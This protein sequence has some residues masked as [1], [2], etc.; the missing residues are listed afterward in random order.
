MSVQVCRT[1]SR[2]MVMTAVCSV[3][4]PST[5]LG[6]SDNDPPAPMRFDAHIEGYP[7][8]GLEAAEDC[9]LFN[10]TLPMGSH[11]V[12]SAC[13]WPRYGAQYQCAGSPNGPCG[14]SDSDRWNDGW[15]WL[16]CVQHMGTLG[17]F[18]LN[19]DLNVGI[20]PAGLP[21]LSYSVA[22]GTSP[23]VPPS[24][25][26]DGGQVRWP[27]Q[28]VGETVDAVTGTPLIQETDLALPFG[29]A[30]F[31]HTRT[32]GQYHE[33]RHEMLSTGDE[34]LASV[35]RNAV[36]GGEFWESTGNGWTMTTSPVLLIDVQYQ[37][38][39][40]EP[41][42][43]RRCV[44][45]PD[46]HHAISFIQDTTSD[47]G[48]YV[49]ASHFGAQLS[50]NGTWV[51]DSSNPSG[52]Y[53][54]IRPTVYR[55][56]L[57]DGAV[58]YTIKPRYEDVFPGFIPTQE[59]RD[60][61]MYSDH[62]TPDQLG[63]C[64]NSLPY[65]GLAE[66]IDDRYGNCIDLEYCEFRARNY[67][68]PDEDPNPDC[69]ECTV[70]YNE[71][72]QVARVRLLSGVE[73]DATSDWMN[74]GEWQADPDHPDAHPFDWSGSPEPG[75]VEWTLLYTYRSFWT[76]YAYEN[77]DDP[78]L[79]FPHA[80]ARENAIH[81]IHAYEGER[82]AGLD[83]TCRTIHFEEFFNPSSA[84]N[85][86]SG[87][88][89]YKSHDPNLADLDP[90]D[91]LEL[92][93]F[94]SEDPYGDDWAYAVHYMYAEP[95][96]RDR[97][98]STV[99]SEDDDWYEAAYAYSCGNARGAARLLK[100]TVTQRLHE[101]DGSS[102]EDESTYRLYRYDAAGPSGAA[103]D[104]VG[105]VH[106]RHQTTTLQH[107]YDHAAIMQM[108]SELNDESPQHEWT[109]NDLITG[110]GP[111]GTLLDERLTE[112]GEDGDEIPEW[113]TRASRSLWEWDGPLVPSNYARDN[114][115]TG[116]WV[117]FQASQF[118]QVLAGADFAA[119]PNTKSMFLVPGVAMHAERGI[120]GA[121]RYFRTYRFYVSEQDYHS[122]ANAFV[123]YNDGLVPLR[124]V[125]HDPHRMPAYDQN[126]TWSSA[127]PVELRELGELAWVTVIDEYETLFEAAILDGWSTA[128]LPRTRRAVYQNAAGFVL[129]DRTW[130]FTDDGVLVSTDGYTETY[131]YDEH[132]RMTHIYSTGWN[133]LGNPVDILDGSFGSSQDDPRL[134]SGLVTRFEYWPAEERDGNAG[135]KGPLDIPME[136]R[137][138]GVQCGSGED[139]I[140]YYSEVTER[141][142]DGSSNEIIRFD[143][144]T[145]LHRFDTPTET[146]EDPFTSTPSTTEISY[147]FVKD[148]DDD[149]DEEPAQDWVITERT[150]LGPPVA[151][152]NSTDLYRARES[153]YYDA[154]DDE[155][156]GKRRGRLRWKAYGM[157]PLAGTSLASR[158]FDYYH[159]D[160]DGRVT[161]LVVDAA[162]GVS[163]EDLVDY[164][165][166]YDTQQLSQEEV[167]AYPDPSGRDDPDY[168]N[169]SPAH[170]ITKT[171]F[172]DRGPL[173]IEQP[174]GTQTHMSYRRFRSGVM[175]TRVARGFTS[176]VGDPIGGGKPRGPGTITRTGAESAVQHVTWDAWIS[177]DRLYNHGFSVIA[178]TEAETDTSGRPTAATQSD[179]RGNERR[180]EAQLDR[181]GM[182]TRRIEP[183]G[184]ITRTA[185]D[186]RG[187]PERVF[188][189]TEDGDAFW[190]NGQ[191]GG[192]EN[193]VLTDHFTY[194]HGETDAGLQI[195]SR[196]FR[197]RPAKSQYQAHNP[198]D[199]T[200]D[201]DGEGWLQQSLYDWR[202]RPVWQ[203]TYA[204]GDGQA[205]GDP[206]R[207]TI[208]LYD[209]L[210][211]VRFVASYGETAPTPDEQGGNAMVFNGIEYD[212]KLSMPSAEDILKTLPHTLTETVYNAAGQVER[213]IEYDT[214]DDTALT[215][216]ATSTYYDR[217]NKETFKTQPST[218][219]TIT[220]NDAEGR[221]LRRLTVLDPFTSSP[222]QIARTEYEYDDQGR[223]I[224]T[225]SFE[226]THHDAAAELTIDS[227]GNAVA[228]WQWSWYD[229]NGRLKATASLGTGNATSD[230]FVNSTP[231]TRTPD[232]PSLAS[233]GTVDR[234]GVPNY[235]ILT[236]YRYDAAG[237]QSAVATQ[238]TAGASPT[239]RVDRSYYDGMGNLRYSK[240]NAHGP[241][242]LRRTAY[243]YDPTT[244][245]LTHIAAVL[246]GHVALEYTGPTDSNAGAETDSSIYIEPDW[247]ADDGTLQVTMLEYQAEVYAGDG[248][249]P[250]QH[251]GWVSAVYLPDEATGQ[252]SSTPSLTF[253]YYPDGLVRSR[254][255][256]LGRLFTHTYDQFG[257]RTLTTID[258]N[259][260][261][262][263]PYEAYRPLDLAD[264][265]EYEY[266]DRDRLVR[267]TAVRDDNG[268]DV[269]IADNTYAYDNLGNLVAE[270]QSHGDAANPDPR[271]GDPQE[272]VGYLWDYA[273]H[274]VGNYLRLAA[275]AYP[276]RIQTGVSRSLQFS[277]G[278]ATDPAS[279]ALSRI[280]AIDD[281]TADLRAQFD[282]AGAGRRTGVH[283]QRDVSSNPATVWQH[284]FTDPNT[285]VGYPGLDRFG[286]PTDLRYVDSVG[287]DIH[288]YR[289]AYNAAGDRLAAEVEQAGHSNTRSW[290][291]GYDELSR[292]T[293]AERGTLLPDLSGL[294]HTAPTRAERTS[295]GL[296]TLGNWTE[297]AGYNNLFTGRVQELYDTS[298][299]DYTLF[300]EEHAHTTDQ[301]NRLR[302]IEVTEGNTPVVIETNA[303]D[304]AGNLIADADY[305]Y[306]Y[307][308][309]NRL[310]S[311]HSRGTLMFHA[312]GNIAG[313]TPGSWQMHMAYDAIGRLVRIQKPWGPAG[314]DHRDTL[315][316][317]DGV[318]RIV[319][320]FKDPV[321][322]PAVPIGSAQGSGYV[323]YTDREYVWGPD[324]IDECLW[325]ITRPGDVLHVLHD[326]S[327]DVVAL[328]DATGAVARQYTF[329]PYGQVIADE[330]FNSPAH[331]RLGH[332]GLFFDRLNTNPPVLELTAN[333]RGLYHNRNRTYD[334]RSG[335]FTS[336]DPNGTGAN[337]LRSVQRGRAVHPMS[338][339]SDNIELY[340]DGLSTYAYLGAAP[341]LQVD[342]FGLSWMDGASPL[343]MAL[344]PKMIGILKSV[345]AQIG[346][347]MVQHYARMVVAAEVAYGVTNPVPGASL[348]FP[349]AA[350]AAG[351]FGESILESLGGKTQVYF[352]TSLGR[353]FIDRLVGGIAYE[354]KTGFAD[355]TPAIRRQAEK[356][357]EL[358]RLGG[359]LA[360]RIE[361]IVWVFFTNPATGRQG[362]SSKLRAFLERQGIKVIEIVQ[363]VD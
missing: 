181:F 53:W 255:D 61:G 260:P 225:A 302:E 361:G 56:W 45:M 332:H 157:E 210:D 70:N 310:A 64:Y 176:P 100:T 328:L 111:D 116:D 142:R 170:R 237:R 192:D 290:L 4:V 334:P 96:R 249:P 182:M 326:A 201:F 29:S 321:V 151:L 40:G 119:L 257:R 1:F 330:S 195:T 89:W 206:L 47:S 180:V 84:G 283:A 43:A 28:L 109:V 20:G 245:Q 241:G 349:M 353:R 265:L 75:I 154:E 41:G 247:D 6:Q 145:A 68:H 39:A 171:L 102:W 348:G 352:R 32:F 226:R 325:Q 273:S 8:L 159:Y 117:A 150:T 331:N 301:R 251:N 87:A 243:K 196:S 350:Q 183:E 130:E 167:P 305:W 147:E 67:V 189:G 83:P 177:G 103:G 143:L 2:A 269:I 25:T 48:V 123:E 26:S 271:L 114:D 304:A 126:G 158:Y 175:E 22:E 216:H 313:G 186:P 244:G 323:T 148:V 335:R 121:E 184:T 312:D 230:Q 97:D 136:V 289:Y 11:W 316:Y 329:D 112:F 188:M 303:H 215:Y 5:A 358:L 309:F 187:R 168:I 345:E 101:P 286:R 311:V 197:A 55:V 207:H 259:W 113:D 356:D 54:S 288:R 205:D 235:A 165:G 179:W 73:F 9:E 132:G 44:F 232:S 262:N 233:D 88:G 317:Y 300:A 293:S 10:T 193:M 166:R 202:M 291:Y 94:A 62:D 95:L 110:I 275:M 92:E 212:S 224:S 363:E 141:L 79:S 314:S 278:D 23:L 344:A 134:T 307:D 46:A 129:M 125:L 267:A 342:P 219:A 99:E 63:A 12:P 295:W 127:T 74:G 351:R 18:P 66:R 58:C 120:G 93:V 76:G 59:D 78:E 152:D 277:Y 72:G 306:Q 35:A 133:S 217:R 198:Q 24:A 15:D 13:W 34:G 204:A 7:T 3:A 282:Y 347:V 163:L 21:P 82:E 236:C 252:P 85:G 139:A 60:D 160:E 185:T 231:P 270:Q 138:K 200:L 258:Y 229:Y 49:A 246:P 287:A 338:P 42:G 234:A 52:G 51:P 214:A 30:T 299:N 318:R 341:G 203:R 297:P 346:A 354:V 161:R 266:D 296:D 27:R 223:Q 268:N 228:T 71:K 222:Y 362:C 98:E 281:L 319:E 284:T 285:P 14:G 50:H 172:S 194:G 190:N 16:A 308:A 36:P 238:R 355:L 292:L 227:D 298:S 118:A 343:D 149:P 174:D 315:L 86:G 272:V 31:R 169:E 263:D 128:E 137:A 108:L 359:S 339:G 156:N 336:S 106:G 254:T 122:T 153:L 261:S 162:A 242:P 140:A 294:D 146:F 320:V 19:V 191:T 33:L 57:Y 105:Y 324:Y 17:G 124:S 104:P 178:E 280:S 81:S 340:T 80:F 239:Y 37:V 220:E 211:R 155:A 357:A 107:L 248:E 253:T 38:L 135:I 264:T 77:P 115:M 276:A 173:I 209:N 69:Q 333:A 327:K 221:V 65:W 208:T 90:I 144:I 256:A 218:A 250:S 274:D 199:G 131:G 240:E 213:V 91:T 337:E 279:D 322:G 164:N 360:E